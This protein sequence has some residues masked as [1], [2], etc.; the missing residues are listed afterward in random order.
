MKSARASRCWAAGLLL[1]SATTCAGWPGAVAVEIAADAE[2]EVL[3]AD[4]ARIAALVSGDVDTLAD[5]LAD[6]LRYVHSSGS[7]D[8]KASLLDLVRSGKSR[9]VAYEP[10]QRIVRF[11]AEGVALDS[12]RARL[13]VETADGLIDTEFLYLACWRLEGDA[14][15]FAAWQSARPPRMPAPPA[16]QVALDEPPMPGSDGSATTFGTGWCDLGEDAFERVNCDPDTWQ[17]RDGVVH[18][19]G[20]PVGVIRTK[21]SLRNLELSLEW[22]HL[23]SGG[24]SGVFLWAGPEAFEGLE[25]GQLPRGGIEVQ[26]LDHGFREKYEAS[27]G[28]IGDWFST[29]GDVFPVGTSRMTPF[30]PISPD[31]SRSFPTA[32]H[33]RGSPD[34]NHYYVRA[35]DGEVR[36]WING[37]EVSGGTGCTPSSGHLCLE[38]EGAPIEFR[39]LRIRELPSPAD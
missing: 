26:I 16:F 39:R 8:D 28:R 2:A 3:A 34:W 14:W 32:G 5:C 31:G 25:P 23:T 37:H 18:C 4:D 7:V 9:Y 35:I 1:M 27:T 10:L 11:P 13:R 29:E 30:P 15:K 24:N 38:S 21:R 20:H 6:D 22:R 19:T 12:G 36:L 33:T 17:W